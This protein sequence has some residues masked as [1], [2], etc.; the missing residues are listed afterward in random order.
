MERARVIDGHVDLPIFVRELY[1]N[2]IDKVDLEKQVC[3]FIILLMVV[4]DNVERSF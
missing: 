4:A 2:N 1:A 3:H